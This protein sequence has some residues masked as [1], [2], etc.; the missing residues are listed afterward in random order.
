MENGYTMNGNGVEQIREI[1]FGQSLREI[2]SKI[3]QVRTNVEQN[4]TAILNTIEDLKN[5]LLSAI[6][7]AE[8]NML[9][10]IQELQQYTEQELQRLDRAHVDRQSL[11]DALAKVANA[12]NTD[13]Q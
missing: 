6:G 9:A 3:S 2:E 11:S 7:N 12:I 1:V 4:Q 13:E 5:Q 10:K 8:N